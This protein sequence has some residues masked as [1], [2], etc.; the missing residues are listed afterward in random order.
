M[1]IQ[2]VS[3]EVRDAIKRKSA[4]ALPNRPSEAGMKP[5]EIKRAFYGPI[6]DAAM[7]ALGEVDRVVKEANEEF[8]KIYDN[9]RAHEANVDNPHGVTAEQVG[10]GNVDNTSDADK[11]VSAA[12][13]MAL[14]ALETSIENAVAAGNAALQKETEARETAVLARVPRQSTDGEAVYLTDSGD[15]TSRGAVALR[16][17]AVGGTVP[18]RDGAGNLSVGTATASLHAVNKAVLDAVV[19]HLRELLVAKSGNQAIDGD[20]SI[21]GDF[22]VAGNSYAKDVES[23]NVKDAVIVANADGIPL[24]ELSGYVIRVSATEAYGILYDAADQCV[25]IG[26]GSFDGQVFSYGA[27]EAQVLATRDEIAH[28]N[29]PLWDNERKTFIDSGKKMSDKLDVSQASS[30]VYATDADGAGQM[31]GFSS[32]A[33]PGALLIRDKDGRAKVADPVT[34]GDIANRA[35][36]LAYGGGTVKDEEGVSYPYSISIKNGYPCMT[37]QVV[38]ETEE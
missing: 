11:P 38:E 35:F 15:G 8:D 13:Q 27:G 28:G 17:D 30:S 36:V 9:E 37:L 16:E 2:K 22:Y 32:E 23:L 3:T 12:G 14:D 31:L 21:S 10:L 25:K 18:K 29:V 20:L 4:H 33:V 34:D 26:L 5:D 7:S 6:T 1:A 19:A 24:A